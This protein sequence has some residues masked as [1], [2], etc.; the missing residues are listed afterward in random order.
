M[1]EG[2]SKEIDL[3]FVIASAPVGTVSMPESGSEPYIG[4]ANVMELA[5]NE[6]SDNF[7]AFFAEEAQTG[8]SSQCNT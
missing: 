5:M 2:K 7:P 3:L 1:P 8:P 6:L 4:L